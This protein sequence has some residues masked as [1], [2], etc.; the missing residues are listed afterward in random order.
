MGIRW[1]LIIL[2]IFDDNVASEDFMLTKLVKPNLKIKKQLDK[3]DKMLIDILN[4]NS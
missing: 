4:F 3:A 1:I 2:N